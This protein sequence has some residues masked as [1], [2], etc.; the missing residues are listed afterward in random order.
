MISV[1]TDAS[2]CLKE[3]NAIIERLG[4][5]HWQ[6]FGAHGFKKDYSVNA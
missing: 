2:L 3:R 4:V 1:D 6:N 5:G